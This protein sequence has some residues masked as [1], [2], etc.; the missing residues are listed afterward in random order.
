MNYKSYIITRIL[1]EEHTKN[2]KLLKHLSKQRTLSYF[3]R[4]LK[5]PHIYLFESFGTES[6]NE[7]EYGFVIVDDFSKLTL[8]KNSL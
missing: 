1:Y 5:Q 8:L 4:P 3:S 2:R 6:I 7:K